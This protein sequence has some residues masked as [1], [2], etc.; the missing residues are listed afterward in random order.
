[1]LFYF[2]IRDGNMLIEDPDG[3]EFPNFE[4]AYADAVL[5]AREMM[6]ENLLAGKP[7]DGKAFEIRLSGHGIVATLPFES[8]IPAQ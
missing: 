3:S 8:V 1:M 4:A 5:A 7:L 2:D 6:A